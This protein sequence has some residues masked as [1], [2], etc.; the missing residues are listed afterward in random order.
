[1][2]AFLFFGKKGEKSKGVPL[3]EIKEMNSQGMSESEMIDGLRK[4]GYSAKDIDKGLSMVVKDKV[5]A[6][7]ASYGRQPQSGGY[8]PQSQDFSQG[9]NDFPGGSPQASNMQSN[10]MGPMG[11]PNERFDVPNFS[12]QREGQMMQNQNLP[13]QAPFPSPAP[14]G[15]PEPSPETRPVQGFPSPQMY[16]NRPSA[17]IPEDLAEAEE[18]EIVPVEFEELIEELIEEK[19]GGVDDK[20]SEWEKKLEELETKFSDMK[21]DVD[22]IKGLQK[23]SK[24]IISDKVEKFGSDIIDIET[25]MMSLEKAFKEFLPTLT[26]N[27]RTLSDLVEKMK[28]KDAI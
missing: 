22:D 3:R 27:V 19:W 28:K 8:P 16:E 25:R 9:R 13:R 21:E 12:Q 2:K 18:E 4:N 1:M 17:G 15:F 6:E 7:T 23:D 11:L 24:K 26:D 20:V 14:G 10:S 5:E